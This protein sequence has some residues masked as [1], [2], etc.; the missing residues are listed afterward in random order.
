[1]LHNQ[2]PKDRPAQTPRTPRRRCTFDAAEFEERRH[3]VCAAMREQGLDV[4]LLSRIE[5][6][7]WLT[8]LDT[9]GFCI[10]HGVVITADGS[11]THISRS[12]DLPTSAT[13][14]SAATLTSG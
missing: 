9:D 4:L 7:Y 1:M 11:I 2:P 8:G 3:R 10:F 6:Q 5:D 13:P 12:A 14:Q